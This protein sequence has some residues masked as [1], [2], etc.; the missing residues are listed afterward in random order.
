MSI[1]T[2][3]QWSTTPT[4]NTDLNG[5]PLAENVMRPS[6]VNNAFQNMMAQIKAGSIGNAGYATTATAAGTTTL[7]VASPSWQ[8]FT[9]TT[10][11]TVVL[12]VTST[13]T[14]GTAYRIVN[15]S[16]GVVTVQSSGAN[17]VVALQAGT[18]AIVT[19]I[20]ISGTTAASWSIQYVPVTANAN[21]TTLTIASTDAGAAA[22]PIIRRRR[23]SASPAVNDVTD[24]DLHNGNNSTPAEVTYAK[25]ETVIIDPTA[26]SEDASRDHYAMVA[27]SL[28]RIMSVG[29]NLD[30]AAIGQIKFP[31]TQNPSSNANTL[32]DYEEGTWTPADASGVGLSFTVAFA[33]YTKIGRMV[34]A[35]FRLTYPATA[36]GATAG[37]GGLP[38]T[39]VA[40]SGGGTTAAG[41]MFSTA[42]SPNGILV[43]A[44][45]SA[46]G[47]FSL[48]NNSAATTLTNVTLSNAVVSGTVIYT[49]AA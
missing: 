13:L 48:A 34:Y 37:I 11:Q 40:V 14:L 17:E 43:A 20:L 46:T 12:P 30:L 1:T 19:C 36:S 28:T 42:A 16:T 33:N 31:A 41:V 47:A 9:G 10:T 21:A 26:A 35:S 39:S 6:D 3:S 23:L 8:F 44:V 29:P 27:G 24:Q 49:A 15:D 22:A 25:E 45:L 5:Y 2:I 32:D 18:A 4:S 38:F 7:T